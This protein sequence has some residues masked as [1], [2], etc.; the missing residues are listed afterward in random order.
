M[1]E[2]GVEE[3][4]DG[5]EFGGYQLHHRVG[6]LFGSGGGQAGYKH[7]ATD[8]DLQRRVR[9]VE[10]R[11]VLCVIR[12]ARF[13]RQAAAAVHVDDVLDYG[14]ALGQ[15][16]GRRGCVVD[17]DGGCADGVDGGEGRGRAAGGGVAYVGVQG[18]GEGEFFAEPEDA[19]ALGEA[20]V[21]DLEG[22][23]G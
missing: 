15:H 20:E 12:L 5:G 14:A 6:L 4:E 21:V 22:H 2:A 13:H 8:G 9:E 1:G 3:G 7:H 10:P 17:H 19:L 11:E 23:F 18:V 16:D